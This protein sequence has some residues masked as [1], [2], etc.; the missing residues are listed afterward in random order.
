MLG[1]PDLD[2]R[3]RLLYVEDA[4]DI[5]G[6]DTTKSSRWTSTAA[7]SDV[8]RKLVKMDGLM[9]IAPF[10]DEV[11]FQLVTRHHDWPQGAG[12]VVRQVGPDVRVRD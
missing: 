1:R 12:E 4:G 3:S 11:Q 7:G 5:A 10:L 2:F 8:L 9:R 6:N